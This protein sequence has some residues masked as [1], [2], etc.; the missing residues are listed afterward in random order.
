MAQ[1]LKPGSRW[2]SAVC[3][4]E[5]IVVK[6]GGE[7]LTLGCGGQAMIEAG[8]AK[9]EGVSLDKDLAGGS[10]VGK[11]YQHESGLELL[12]TKAGAGTLT[13]DGAL[14]PLKESKPLPAS[15]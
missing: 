12:C 15:D 10:P 7:G 6:A 3:D 2:A 1:V 14:L 8:S 5:V 9:P 13:V 4:T 11:R